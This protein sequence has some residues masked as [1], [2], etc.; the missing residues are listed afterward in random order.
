MHSPQS[1]TS[2][3]GLAGGLCSSTV[4][5]HMASLL[6]IP[7]IT[8]FLATPPLQPSLRDSLLFQSAGDEVLLKGSA[9]VGPFRALNVWGCGL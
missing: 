3:P 6:F 1:I 9:R 2:F 8:Q 4:L 5:V 7:K